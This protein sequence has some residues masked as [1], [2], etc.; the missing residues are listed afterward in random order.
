MT[1]AGSIQV[2]HVSKRFRDRAGIARDALL[3][4]SLDVR[5]GEF[6]CLLGPSGC[7]KTTLL[8]LV[9]GFDRPTSGRVLVDGVAVE[10]CDPKRVAI[11]QSYA[12]FPWRSVLG[13]VEYGLEVQG[14]PRATRREI[15]REYVRL[16][17]L[18][19]FEN[20]H[21]H[22]ISG[23]MQQRVAI[24]RALAVDPQCL[25]MDEPLGALDA[26]NRIRMQE[27]IARIWMERSKTIL[28]VTHDVEESVF[29]ADR[30]VV[31]GSNPGRVKRVL[32][33]S[34]A[35]PRSRTST[36]FVRIRAQ[37]YR[38]LELVH[39]EATPEFAI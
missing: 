29:L 17:G 6:V 28:F 39:E 34:L 30:I 2:D 3:G 10:D 13:N 36:D 21:P 8:N 15:S 32:D 14:M 33:V 4:V 9:A 20:Y 25:L 23:G 35:R 19:K 18:E 31:M 38:E 16:V 7:G 26:M 37:V 11:F 1:G 5:S 12:L 24:A 22:Q 27:E